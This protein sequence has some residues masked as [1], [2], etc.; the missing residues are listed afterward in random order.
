M[1]R[2]FAGIISLTSAPNPVFIPYTVSPLDKMRSTTALDAST[3][4]QAFDA[5]ST[6]AP[7]ETRLISADDRVLPSNLMVAI[8]HRHYRRS[9]LVCHQ[10]WWVV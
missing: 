9:L 1:A 10:Q 7:L 8:I 4:L 5:T 2:S 3:L 6:L